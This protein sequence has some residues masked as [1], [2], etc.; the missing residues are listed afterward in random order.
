MS[1][2]RLLLFLQIIFN[3]AKILNFQ[4][5]CLNALL[6]EHNLDETKNILLLPFPSILE[7]HLYRSQE[8]YSY[9]NSVV[10]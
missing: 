3:G 2:S 8:P 6:F 10:L 4:D 1:D 7:P 9:D 5:I